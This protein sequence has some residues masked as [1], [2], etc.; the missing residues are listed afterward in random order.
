M[1]WALQSSV[2]YSSGGVQCVEKD[3]HNFWKKLM[4][5]QRGQRWTIL[6]C[7][8]TILGMK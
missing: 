4:A 2:A 3:W 7:M 8:Q 5:Y 6:Q 1:W